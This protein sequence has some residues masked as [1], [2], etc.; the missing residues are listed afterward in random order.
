MKD[1]D[2]ISLDGPADRNF[3]LKKKMVKGL[4]Q[5]PFKALGKIGLSLSAK[6]PQ[7]MTLPGAG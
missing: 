7:P 3:A 1:K 4:Y 6:R 5:S 2:K